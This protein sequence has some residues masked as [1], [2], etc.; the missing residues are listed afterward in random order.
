MS[1]K[2]TAIEN[3]THP[4]PAPPGA[5]LAGCDAPDSIKGRIAYVTEQERLAGA[6][7]GWRSCTGCHETSEGYSIGFPRSNVFGCEVGSGCS[8]CGGLGVVWEYYSE[9]DL[10]AMAEDAGV[11]V[12]PTGEQNVF[13]QD[14][15][16]A[17]GWPKP[18]PPPG[19]VKVKALEWKPVEFAR[20][21]LTAE[22]CVGRYELSRTFDGLVASLHSAE[23]HHIGEGGEDHLK[24]LCQA[25]FE[26]RVNADLLPAVGEA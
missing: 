6:A 2:P 7:A 25:D 15:E 16:P 5:V 21:A 23:M 9:A 22:C 14:F 13:P 11:P 1:I 10:K 4:A 19:G 26:R 17:G 3:A 24:A 18:A 8:E 12:A 20:G